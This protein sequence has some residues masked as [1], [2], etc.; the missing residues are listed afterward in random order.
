MWA[1][2]VIMQ[3]MTCKNAFRSLYRVVSILALLAAACLYPRVVLARAGCTCEVTMKLTVQRA[4]RLSPALDPGILTYGKPPMC[5]AEWMNSARQ[6]EMNLS[7]L[8]VPVDIYVPKSGKHYREQDHVVISY[9]PGSGDALIYANYFGFEHAPDG[10]QISNGPNDVT[11]EFSKDWA[12]QPSAETVPYTIKAG[13]DIQV[14]WR[15]DR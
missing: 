2:T 4:G 3:S 7:L 12:H 14:R 9:V 1:D 10:L 6:N 13:S 5:R 8:R 15:C 11:F